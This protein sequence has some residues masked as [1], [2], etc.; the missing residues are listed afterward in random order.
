MNTLKDTTIEQFIVALASKS[1]VP[2]G[3]GAAAL[4]GAVGTALGNMVGSLTLG[5]KKYA[6]VEAD[7]IRLK[8]KADALQGELLDLAAK[9]AEM[10]EPVRRAYALP[11][12]TD[13][14]KAAK[15]RVIEACLREATGVP[16]EIMRK[17]ALAI[18][19]HEEFAVKGS[20]IAISD[21][22]VGVAC[23][24]AALRGAA[25]NVYINTKAMA[26][27]ES[28]GKINRCADSLLIGYEKRAEKVYTDVKARL[29][30]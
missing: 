10:F 3:G 11:A 29:K 24:L 19:L 15:A 18:E 21:V 6:D 12:N 22:G 1:P 4:A 27:R 23:C 9:D 2:G 30:G 16:L 25:L 17:C 5:K 26:D 14:E 13:A 28:A 8:N 7:I 20:A